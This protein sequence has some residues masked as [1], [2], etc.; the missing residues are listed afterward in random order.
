[1]SVM[2]Q[3]FHEMKDVIALFNEA[4]SSWKLFLKE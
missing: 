3:I 1:M 2:V 4:K